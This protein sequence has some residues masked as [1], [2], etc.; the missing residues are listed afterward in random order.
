MNLVSE[1]PGILRDWESVSTFPGEPW[2]S[3]S[4]VVLRPSH[5]TASR[6]PS[7]NYDCKVRE[8]VNILGIGLT[9]VGYQGK[10]GLLQ[11]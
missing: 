7:P 6:R 10:G 3:R 4:K 2:L 9:Q 8:T 5:D 11:I 1:G